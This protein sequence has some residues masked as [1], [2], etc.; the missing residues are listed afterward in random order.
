ME[1]P[2]FFCI[3]TSADVMYK[4]TSENAARYDRL[5]KEMEYFLY[6][7][8]KK[9]LYWTPIIRRKHISTSRIR[10]KVASLDQTLPESGLMF[11]TPCSGNIC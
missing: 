5:Q 11:F 8:S 2:L 10:L 4:V 9:N 6:K 7:S 3:Y 1:I